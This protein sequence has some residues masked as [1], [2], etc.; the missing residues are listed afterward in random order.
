MTKIL[1]AIL[2]LSTSSALAANYDS[3]VRTV[4]GGVVCQSPLRLSEAIKAANRGDDAWN[5]SIGCTRIRGGIKAIRINPYAGLADPWQIR[6][7]PDDAPA[8]TVW[9]YAPTFQTISGKKIWPY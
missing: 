3:E 1:A 6:L 9:G 5:A 8:V 2:A 7:M 4:D